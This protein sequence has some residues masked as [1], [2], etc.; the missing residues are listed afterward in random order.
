MLR[1]H[2]C[3][4][5]SRQTP[6]ASVPPRL[7]LPEWLAAFFTIL[8]VPA[9]DGIWGALALSFAQTH[10]KPRHALLPLPPT[11][12]K[13]FWPLGIMPRGGGG[14]GAVA[15]RLPGPDLFPLARYPAT[16]PQVSRAKP[17]LQSEP[18]NLNAA[19]PS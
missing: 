6:L 16:T 3:R 5:S 19:Q 18:H 1:H 15:L 2:I 13:F 8:T 17:R 14:L 4:G 11:P 10:L 9:L 12:T 7:C